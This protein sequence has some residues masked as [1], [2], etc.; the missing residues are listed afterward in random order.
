MTESTDEH[1]DLLRRVLRAEADAVVPSP[2]GLEIIRARIEQ[3]GSRGLFWWRAAA[4]AAG[5]VLVAATVVIVWPQIQGEEPQQQTVQ[6]VVDETSA[7]EIRATSRAPAPTA[8]TTSLPAK[9]PPPVPPVQT[10]SEEPKPTAPAR[11]PRQTPTRSD[12][13]P[14]PAAGEPRAGARDDCPAEATP[15]PTPTP[16][17]S[18]GSQTPGEPCPA[19]ECPPSDADPAPSVVTTPVNTGA[20]ATPN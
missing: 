15:T 7:P 1:G 13:C 18:G 11:T 5:A 10:P 17:D 2:D 4:S 16:S 6:T 8:A 19:D 9:Q 20:D 3:R 14:T 12:P